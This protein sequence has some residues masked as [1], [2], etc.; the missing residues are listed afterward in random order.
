M[1]P[2]TG[3]F[4]SKTEAKALTERY[5]NENPSGSTVSHGFGITKL[6]EVLEQTDVVGIRIYYGISQNGANNDNKE[7]IIVGVDSN[8]RDILDTGKILDIS[9]PCPPF[10]PDT[11]SETL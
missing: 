10:C 5:R 2:N 7:L 1:D 3:G 9:R 8:N 4:I 11:G 6:N